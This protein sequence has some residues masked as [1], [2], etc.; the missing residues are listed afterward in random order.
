MNFHL[1]RL[2][3]RGLGREA[4]ATQAAVKCFLNLFCFAGDTPLLTPTGHKKIQEFKPGDWV[5]SAPE[6]DPEAPLEAKL[7]EEV[8]SNHL[9][10]FEVHVGGQI[11]RTTAGHPFYERERGWIPAQDLHEGSLLRSHDG[12]WVAVAEIRDAGEEAPVYNLRIADY[13]T[14]FVGSREWGFS[15]WSHNACSATSGNNAAAV[16]G[17]LMHKAYNALLAPFGYRPMR[18]PSGRIAD[19]VNIR[20]R[21][22]RE[23]KPN[24]PRAAARGLKQL[25]DYVKELQSIYGGPWGFFLDTYL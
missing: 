16:T 2:I 7:V 1:A 12:R 11:I 4:P 9:A 22:V 23:L 10:L 18:L 25:Q 14:Y 8:F 19:A 21:T 3:A 5:L 24:N 20:A 17:K 13:H 6:N 15:V